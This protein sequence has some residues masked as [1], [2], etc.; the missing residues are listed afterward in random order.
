MSDKTVDIL[1]PFAAICLHEIAF[2]AVAATKSKDRARLSI[3][4]DVHV[5]L[6]VYRPYQHS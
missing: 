2:S 4:D 3:E 6:Y 1:S 5:G